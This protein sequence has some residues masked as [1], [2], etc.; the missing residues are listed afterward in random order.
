MEVRRG[1]GVPG[2]GKPLFINTVSIYAQDPDRF[3]MASFRSGQ[4]LMAD[5]MKVSTI[6]PIFASL[7]VAGVS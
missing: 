7:N 5:G 3:R 6:M 4:E 1:V 2:G